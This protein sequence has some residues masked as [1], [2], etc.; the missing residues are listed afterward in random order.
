MI[1]AIPRSEIFRKFP[2]VS[3]E[4]SRIQK[5]LYDD[6]E[7]DFFDDRESKIAYLRSFDALLLQS[8]P[9][10][11]YYKVLCIDHSNPTTYAQTLAKRLIALTDAIGVKPSFVLSH[12]KL[13]PADL[14]KQ[15]IPAAGHALKDLNNLLPPEGF[16]SALLVDRN[17]FPIL[18]DRVFQFFRA[19]A[20]VPEYLFFCDRNDSFAFF[21]CSY[22]NVHT[23]EFKKEIISAK[24]LFET[25][26]SELKTRCYDKFT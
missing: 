11:V 19:G 2:N 25:G 3:A 14:I 12:L 4:I 18:I 9:T 24:M 8:K 16:E 17:D 23:I 5:E 26:W 20:T 10:M 6:D 13:E 21:L 15:N 22:G 7:L 1:Q